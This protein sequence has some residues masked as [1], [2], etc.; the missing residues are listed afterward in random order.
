MLDL[1]LPSNL[2]NVLNYMEM[3]HSFGAVLPNPLLYFWNAQIHNTTN[4]RFYERG[5]T[6]NYAL[7]L[8]GSDIEMIAV[9]ILI[10]YLVS[11]LA[12]KYFHEQIPFPPKIWKNIEIQPAAEDNDSSIY[13]DS[14]VTL[15]QYMR[16]I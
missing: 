15:D 7:Y 12:T 6:T 2:S 14:A 3:V 16:S 10:A 1:D 8:C 11:K 13:Q 4:K 9:Q 5:F